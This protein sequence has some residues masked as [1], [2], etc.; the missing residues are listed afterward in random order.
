MADPRFAQAEQ[1]YDRLRAELNAGRLTGEAFERALSDAMFEFHGRFWMLGANS[2][3][4]YASVGDGWV[5]ASPP[6]SAV[7]PG[8]VAAPTYSAPPT[9][10]AAATS[11]PTS[12]VAA[13][14]PPPTPAAAATPPP[15]PSAPVRV[16]AVL[17]LVGVT[18]FAVFCFRTGYAAWTEGD[19]IGGGIAIGFGLVL[20]GAMVSGAVA[21]A[22]H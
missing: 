8:P 12:A 7:P 14:T 11:P 19:R 4:W 13:T 18:A 2:R 9:P 3:R 5:E 6:T 17:V 10:T 22:R 20:V 21:R 16:L 15:K 1:Q